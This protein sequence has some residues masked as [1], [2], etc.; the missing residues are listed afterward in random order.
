MKGSLRSCL[1]LALLTGLAAIALA[2]VNSSSAAASADIYEFSSIPST[3]EAGG[4]PNIL[5]SLEVATRYTT[6]GEYPPCECHDAKNIL[7]HN[8]PGVIANQ[9]VLS[10]CTA[11]QL[12]EFNCS[13]DAQA[14]YMVI[15][16]PL[17]GW[18]VFPLYRTVPQAGQ[19]SLF[20]FSILGTAQYM[21]VTARTG[22]DYGLDFRFEG[23]NHS[24]PAT[25]TYTMFWGVP[26]AHKHDLLRF[27]PGGEALMCHSN[28]MAE[29]VEEKVPVDCLYD[30]THGL[31]GKAQVE[32]SLPIA[33]FTQNPTTCV[34]PMTSSVDVTFYD[35]MTAHA[36]SEWPATTG[37]DKL[38]FNPSLAAGPTTTDTDSASGLAVDLVVPQFED[39]STPS[40]SEIRGDSVELP[41]GFSINPSA[42]DGKTTCSDA[43]ANL[44]NELAAECPEYSKIGTTELRSSAL[45]GPIFGYIYL[46]T[47]LPGDRWRLIVTAS[48]FATNVKLVGST[49]LNPS[50]GQVV[51][52]FEN[53]PQN[54]FEE[55][56]LHFFGS[57]RGLFATPTQCGTY[58][59]NA[60]F[61]P[62]AAQLSEQAST[63]FFTVDSGP[64]GSGCPNGPRPFSP[65]FE[66]GVEDNTAG[67]HSPFVLQFSR[68]DGDQNVTG[69][70]VKAPPGLL[71]NLRGIPYCPEAAIAR[72]KSPGYSG[73]VEQA[74]PACPAASRVGSAIAGAGAGTHPV[75][76]P[77]GVYLAG[78]YKGAPLSLV[79]SFPALSGPYDLGVVPVRVALNLDRET[80]Q[81]TAISDPL[82][83]IQEGVP[84]RTRFVRINLDRQGFALNPT[85]CDPLSVGAAITGDEGATA[86]RSTGFQATDCTDLSFAPKMSLRLEGSS[87]R[88][89]HPALDARI[90]TGAGEANIARTVVAM[91]STLILD[92]AHVKS[93]CTRVQF[94][95]DA[96]PAASR[97]GEATASTPLLDQPLR[98]SVYLRS[99]PKGNLPNLVV[100]LKGV[101]DIDLVGKIDTKHGGL[102]TTFA[103]LPDAP[104]SSFDLNLF[105]GGKGLLQSTEPLCSSQQR[106][107]VQMAGQNGLVRKGKLE[108]RTACGGR[109]RH[110]RHN[111]IVVNATG[112]ARR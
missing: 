29:L 36:Q 69:V 22:S 83:Q 12:A 85:N 107:S 74:S 60:K 76:V 1:R 15:N 21:A 2:A 11:T 82:P 73:A 110:R 61:H 81:I 49:H 34:G 48:G 104:I 64:G 44:D 50:T 65:S 35:R 80:A 54:P 28:P 9:H 18:L 42:A 38:S 66:A 51:T 90:S 32:S 68:A 7:V 23:I 13:A 112:G 8:P 3:A 33:P 56:N 89:G 79:V 14:G 72:L 58:P 6:E 95:A 27:P 62:W 10:V 96:C 4:H 67:V 75:Y 99:N 92:N 52:S 30:T 17:L 57:E 31:D 88:R 105:G 77:G 101:V 20:V 16:H 87:K 100:S 93:P 55:F 40:P 5:T 25:S 70:D 59:V 106:A 108:I 19:A 46:G 103:S 24:F 47:P 102:R 45:P 26:G 84:L 111:R 94:A 43:Q 53:L 91:P 98:G 71:A 78:P 86:T 37:C 63:Q 97:I 109:Q 41:V 39:P